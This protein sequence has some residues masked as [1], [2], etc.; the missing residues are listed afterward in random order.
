MT[1]FPHVLYPWQQCQLLLIPISILFYLYITTILIKRNLLFIPINRS[2]RETA[3]VVVM[4]CDVFTSD[5]MSRDVFIGH[6]GGMIPCN[7]S[8]LFKRDTL[9]QL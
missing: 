2:Q 9:C 1:P 6:V 8:G 7:K 3:P 5:V 4:S